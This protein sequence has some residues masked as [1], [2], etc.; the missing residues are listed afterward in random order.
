MRRR[1]AERPGDLLGGSLDLLVLRTLELGPNH[2]FAIA[3]SILQRSKAKLLVEEGS[4]YPALHRLEARGWIAAT[5]G[6]SD[7][8]RR[9]RFYE[10][11]RTGRKQLAA[12][13]HRWADLAA[14]VARIMEP[15][16]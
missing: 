1:A 3:Q 7:H 9:A 15:L 2:G 6:V 5:W 4:L 14:A 16:P 11:T 8:N 12:E 13:A 10:L